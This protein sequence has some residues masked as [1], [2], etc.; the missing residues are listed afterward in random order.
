MSD[1][2][3]NARRMKIGIEA[4]PHEGRENGRSG[5][6]GKADYSWHQPV[7][8]ESALGR[9][10]CQLLQQRLRLLQ[11]ERVEAFGE[12][13][14]DRSEQ[15]AGRITHALITPESRHAYR[16]AQFPI[17]LAADALWKEPGRNTPA[18]SLHV[19]R[20]A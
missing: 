8:G 12:P 10:S 20:V 6:A 5:R 7:S 17:L 11:I 19:A 2:K 18:L 16:R 9:V 1:P 13:A 3:P 4:N 14:V 15:F